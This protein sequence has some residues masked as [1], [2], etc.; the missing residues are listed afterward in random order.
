MFTAEKSE[1]DLLQY[2]RLKKYV[3]TYES[4][5]GFLFSDVVKIV[6]LCEEYE[7]DVEI[8]RQRMLEDYS[9]ERRQDVYAWFDCIGQEFCDRARCEFNDHQIR[10]E[11]IKVGSVNLNGP[12]ILI[13]PLKLILPKKLDDL[14]LTASLT[15]LIET[16]C[17]VK[18]M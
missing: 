13:R 9:D 12:F 16:Q 6:D 8:V 1:E 2:I 14:Q 4:L 15:N 3:Q 17:E 7:I 5:S 18:V 10:Y 11:E